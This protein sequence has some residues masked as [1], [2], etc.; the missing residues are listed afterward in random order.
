MA[1]KRKAG[2]KSCTIV[3]GYKTKKGKKVKGYTRK[4]K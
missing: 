3:K 1:K 4:K 2:S